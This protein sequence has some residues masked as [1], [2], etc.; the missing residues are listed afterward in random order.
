MKRLQAVLVVAA[1]LG[2]APGAEPVLAG[3]TLLPQAH[4]GD[5]FFVSVLRRAGAPAA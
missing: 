1:F 3:R 5:G 4:D 2:G